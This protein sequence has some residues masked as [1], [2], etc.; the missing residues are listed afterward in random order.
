MPACVQQLLISYPPENSKWLDFM[1]WN[2]NP[3]IFWC[4]SAISPTGEV[5]LA[6]AGLPM[7][8]LWIVKLTPNGSLAWSLKLTGGSASING[9][10]PDCDSDGNVY[11][12]WGDMTYPCGGNT[13]M[14]ISPSGAILWSV[15][16]AYFF[17]SYSSAPC[18]VGTV[19]V[20]PTGV[21]C[22]IGGRPTVAIGA[23]WKRYVVKLNFLGVAEWSHED[24]TSSID[25]YDPL[26]VTSD[27]TSYFIGADSFAISTQV[28]IN[29]ISYTGSVQER[30]YINTPTSLYY[31]AER[32]DYFSG[33]YSPRVIT[34]PSGTHL[35]IVFPVGDNL[36]GYGRQV[37]ICVQMYD[38][39]LN[40]IWSVV[41]NEVNSGFYFDML[42]LDACAD[43]DGNLHLMY[44]PWG[45]TPV[46]GETVKLPTKIFKISGD[47]G[48][49]LS[50]GNILYRKEI[51][52]I[53]QNESVA[54]GG[55]VRCRGGKMVVTTC[56]YLDA[57]NWVPVVFSVDLSGIPAGTH[58]IDGHSYVVTEPVSWP[59]LVMDFTTPIVSGAS[60]IS[61]PTAPS[62]ITDSLTL[63]TN[64]PDASGTLQ[65]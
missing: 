43:Q 49:A 3:R 52:N 8:S 15:P 55:S 48:T 36:T 25:Q 60:P 17:S 13:V 45:L 14:K 63:V 35:F 1:R 19:K 44:N 51:T 7:G 31:K 34:K 65:L 9:S 32:S 22:Q 10:E 58:T 38:M 53:A 59:S 29:R 16:L 33:P 64:N 24:T 30:F 11:V 41:Y 62:V 28:L 47:V 21:L 6:L 57:S 54:C 18:T 39:A 26:G 2:D 42:L 37:G 27:G 56:N 40:R 50:F 12:A 20:V 5:F 23:S 46:T 4:K 61:S